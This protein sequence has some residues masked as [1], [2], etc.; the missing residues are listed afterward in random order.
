M[1]DDKRGRLPFMT[2]ILKGSKN[3]TD[4]I[5]I[6]LDIIDFE[7]II[8]DCASQKATRSIFL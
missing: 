2:H 7:D 1:V 5:N 8:S 4:F 6:M 3:F